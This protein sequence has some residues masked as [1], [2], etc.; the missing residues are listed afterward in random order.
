MEQLS[1]GREAAHFSL[2]LLSLIDRSEPLRGSWMRSMHSPMTQPYV[3][4]EIVKT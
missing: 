3:L 2:I 1:G 4:M